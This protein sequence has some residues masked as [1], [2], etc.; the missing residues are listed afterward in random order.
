MHLDA[1]CLRYYLIQ[2][3]LFQ[4]WWLVED[5]NAEGKWEAQ[6]FTLC[7]NTLYVEPGVFDLFENLK[8]WI[9]YSPGIWQDL[10]W[11][12]Y[13]AEGTKAQARC[14]R[15]VVCKWWQWWGWGCRYLRWRPE[16]MYIAMPHCLT[17]TSTKSRCAWIVKLCS[18]VIW[19]SANDASICSS[20]APWALTTSH[21]VSLD[22]MFCDS[23][24]AILITSLFFG[25]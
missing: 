6:V 13:L 8:R 3:Y 9:D 4:A 1:H 24:L 14:W 16:G 17:L 5:F 21:L 23:N 22:H 11:Q 19:Q 15:G 18:V 2:H 25:F 20:P 7:L 10:A 12:C